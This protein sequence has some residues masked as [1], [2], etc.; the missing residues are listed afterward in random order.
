MAKWKKGIIIR[1][2]DAGTMWSMEVA[3]KIVKGKPVN[4][5]QI[6]G[7]W[8]PIMYALDSAYDISSNEFPFYSE[9]KIYEN[10]IGQEILYKP[11]PV[12][13]ASAW[14][15]TYRKFIQLKV[16]DKGRIIKKF[17]KIMP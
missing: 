14:R 4:I 10:V 11:D 15:P 6:S 16:T 8:R 5:T 2:H 9:K 12:F 17:K 1:V 3:E 13:G 7:D